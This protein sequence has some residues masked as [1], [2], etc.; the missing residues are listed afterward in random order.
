MTKAKVV[1]LEFY[2]ANLRCALPEASVVELLPAASLTPLPDAPP[3][4]MGLSNVRGTIVPVLDLRTRLGLAPKPLA[5]S[6]HF[7]LTRTKQRLLA[8]R[9]DRAEALLEL[10]PASIDAERM[11]GGAGL[12]AGVARMPDGLMLIHDPEKFLSEAEALAMERA[13]SGPQG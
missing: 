7:I 11:T 4:V 10:D 12:V 3:I 9:V 1:V 8:L 6:D 13:I 2:L 5:P